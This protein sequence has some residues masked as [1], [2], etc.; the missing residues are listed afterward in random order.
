MQPADDAGCSAARGQ[1]G[2]HHPPTVPHAETDLMID[3]PI[4]RESPIRPA[5]IRPRWSDSVRVTTVEH[6]VRPPKHHTS[7]LR[8]AATHAEQSGLVAASQNKRPA[9]GQPTATI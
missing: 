5:A 4:P 2:K 8:L 9:N 3:R 1:P 7:I 6:S